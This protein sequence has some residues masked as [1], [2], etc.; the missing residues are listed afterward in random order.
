MPYGAFENILETCD[1]AFGWILLK[2]YANPWESF[3]PKFPKIT[4]WSIL[5]ISMDIKSSWYKQ[6]RA[7]MKHTQSSITELIPWGTANYKHPEAFIFDLQDNLIKPEPVVCNRNRI[8]IKTRVSVRKDNYSPQ[9]RRAGSWETEVSEEEYDQW[10]AHVPPW[11]IYTASGPQSQPH[12][13]C[14]KTKVCSQGMQ[15]QNQGPSKG[16]GGQG[17]SYFLCTCKFNQLFTQW[18]D[19]DV[20]FMS[21]G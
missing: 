17:H 21:S 4:L 20:N 10:S 2:L 6:S 5:C 1:Y 15:L 16:V 7:S 9:A 12:I 3:W 11:D 14:W 19:L 13:H 18:I 8:R